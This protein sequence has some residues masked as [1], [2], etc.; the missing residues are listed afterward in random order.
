M[1]I[2]SWNVN[3]LR[4][5]AKK[6]FDKFL[7]EYNPDV[8]CIQETKAQLE[9]LDT[10]HTDIGDYYSYFFSAKKKG[11]SG[12]GIYSKFIFFFPCFHSIQET[13]YMHDAPSYSKSTR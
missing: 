2:M 13:L 3:G 8:L 1:Y 7:L 11:Y 6:G 10:I 4:A 5:I 9:N 12:V